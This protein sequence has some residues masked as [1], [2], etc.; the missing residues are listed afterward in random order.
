MNLRPQHVAFTVNDMD[1]SIKWYGDKLGAKVA[2]RY[3]K[4]GMKITQLKINGFQLE[5]FDF[6]RG[7]PLPEYRQN[8]MD[9]LHVVGIKHLCLETGNLE[10]SVAT[11]KKK[12]VEFVTEV[13][14]AGFGGK[15]IF[16]RDCNGILIE[17][18]QSPDSI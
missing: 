10:D 12:G 5:L 15:Y 16:F 4:H 6:E 2:H 7:K 18:Y 17:L 9:D 8:L 13:D 3:E 14:T 1:E 11:L